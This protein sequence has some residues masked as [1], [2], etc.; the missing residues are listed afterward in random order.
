MGELESRRGAIAEIAGDL[1]ATLVAGTDTANALHATLES[2]DRI[3]ARF[4][5]KP[6]EAATKEKG[7]PF[8]IRQYT[9]MLQELSASTRELNALAARVDRALPVVQQAT[10]TVSANMERLTSQLFWR[11][12]WLLVIAVV[13]IFA[14]ALAYRATV[15]RLR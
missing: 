14:A 13:L 11:L 15:A 8:D 4:A 1:R 6:G 2:L 12:V 5:A 3:T 7:P 10:A 9:Q